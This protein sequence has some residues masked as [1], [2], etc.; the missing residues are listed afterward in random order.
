LAPQTAQPAA[1]K[2]YSRAQ[3]GSVMYAASLQPDDL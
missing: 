1:P 3:S 2:E